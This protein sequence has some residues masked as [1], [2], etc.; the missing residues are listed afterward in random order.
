VLLLDSRLTQGWAAYDRSK[1]RSGRKIKR[2]RRP[3]FKK[4]QAV[5]NAF[6]KT[7]RL[8]DVIEDE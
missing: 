6:A 1:E 8:A 7:V 4:N 5:Q 3:A 2:A